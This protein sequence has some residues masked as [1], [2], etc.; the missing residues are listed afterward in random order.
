ML[1]S[2]FCAQARGL[3]PIALCLLTGLLS[4]QCPI[5]VNAGPDLY[6]CAPTSPAQLD[7]SISG[8]YL[9]FTWTPTT[10][11]QGANTLSPTV[12]VTQTT[13]YVLKATAANFSANTIDNG[14]FEQ[15]N[16]GFT[17]D[18]GYNPGNLMP[19][20]VYDVIDNPQSD[21]PGFAPCNDHTSGSGNMMVVNG[22]GSPNQ[23]VWCQTVVVMPNT[24]Y[25]LSC[26]VT[27]VVAVSPALLQFSINGSSVGPI[28]QAPG[29][30]CVWQNFYSTWNSGG[31]SSATICVVNQNTGLGG[32]DFALDD[33]VFAPVCMQTDTVKVNVITITAVANPNVYTIPCAGANITLSGIGS[34]TGASFTYAWDTPTGN[35]VSGE[36]TLNPV[37]NAPGSYTLTVTYDGNG[38]MCTKTATVNVIESPNPLS[39]WINPTQPLGCGAPTLTLIGN[40]SQSGFSTYQWTTTNGNILNNPNQ[41]NILINQ[42]GEYDLLV[43]NSNTGCTATASIVVTAATSAPTA[44]ATANGPLT[45]TQTTATLSGAGSS[46]GATIGY[47]WTTF[48]GGTISSGQ[49]SQN[50]VAGSA[51]TYVLAVTNSSSGC[52]ATDTVVLAANTAPPTTSIQP[53]GVLDCNTDTLSL[54][55]TVMPANAAPSWTA[56][57]GG[58]IAGGQNTLSPLVTAA[59]TYTLLATNPV[60]GCTASTAVVVTANY[61]PPLAAAQSPNNLTCQSPSVTLSG[62]G[63]STG[64]NM[65][66][67]WT[68]SPGGNIVSGGATLSPVVNAAGTYTLLV[69]NTTN[70]CTATAGVTV[71]ADQNVL[72]AMANAPDT[73]NCTAT[74]VILNSTGSSSG[75]TLFYAWTTTNGNISGPANVP[76]PTATLPG[77]YQLL[78]TNS[79]NGCSATDLAI[80]AQNVT[81]PQLQ[82]SIPAPGFLS[83]AT[84]S[85][86]LQGQ[87]GSLPG[88]FTYQWTAANGGNIVSNPTTLTP[89]VNTGGQYTLTATN[90]ANGCTG[91]STVTLTTQTGTPVATIAAPGPLTCTTPT[92]TL[93]TA[94]SS[95]GAN[96]GYSWTA[97]N[98]GNITMGATTPNLVVSAAGTY[99]LL[100]TN[101]T[102][103]CTTTAS[104][105]VLADQNV[106][107]ALANAPDTLNCT[108]TTV[109][110]NSTGSS[111][112]PTLVYAW[113]TTNGNFS[114][115]TNVP[116]PIATLP[117]TYQLL[118]TNTANGCTA[119]D[120]ALVNQN[121]TPPQLQI[122]TPAPGFLSCATPSLTLQGQNGSLPGNFAYQWTVANGGNIVSNPTT[123]TPTVN[124]GGQYTLT[125]TN[126][127]NG[128]TGQSTVTLTAQ[129]STPVATIAAPGP[130][131]CTAQ[132]QTLNSA[133]SSA[134]AN[135]AYSWTAAN[136]GNITMGAT[137][138]SPIVNAA[139]TYNLLISNTYNGCT[140]S[141]STVVVANNTPPPAEAGAAGLLTCTEPVF[142]LLGNPA[143]PTANLVFQWTT[144]NGQFAGNPNSV[145]VNVDQAGL[146]QLLVTDPAN[147]CT[148]TDSVQVAANQQLPAVVIAPP[149][150]LTCS[151]ST[152]TLSAVATGSAPAYQWQTGAGQIVSGSTS[153]M[154]LIAASGSYALTVTDGTNGCT[155]SASVTVTED[156]A[157]PDVQTA[158]VV[159]I[160]CATPSQTITGQ[161][162]SLPGTFTYNWVAANGG[163]I[164]SGA[165]SLLPTVDAG[166]DYM[167]TTT[168]TDNGCTSVLQVTVAQNTVL[169]TANAGPDS[170]LS[171]SIN[172]LMIN[173]SGLGAPNLA[174]AWTASNGGNLVSGGATPTPAIDQP[175]SYTLLV[176][177]PANGCT[178]SDAVQ[179]QNDVNAPQAN[180]GLPA[181]L[182]CTVQ[183]TTLNATA[184]QGADFSY[185]WT[186]MNGNL[187]SN[188]TTLSPTVN[189]PGLYQFAVTNAAN[190]CVSTSTVAVS[191]DVLPPVIDAG[192]PVTLSCALPALPLAGTA[193]GTPAVSWTT[194][195]GN[196]ISGAGTLTPPVNQ[197]GTYLLTAT[198]PANGCTATDNVTVGIDT[199][200]PV[201]SAGTA[202]PLN[203]SA[204][205]TTV[206]GNVTTPIGPFTVAWT[207][208]NGHFSG[209]QN[210]LSALVDAPG[211]YQ[212]TI[213][214]TSNGC[215]STTQTTVLQNIMLPT[216]M[217]GAPGQIT[218]TNPG[219]ALQGAGSSLG[220]NYEYLW[221][222]GNGGQIQSGQT[223]L[224]PL[225]TAGGTYALVVTD[226]SNG[227]QATAT[228]TVNLNT[229]PPTVAILPPQ[230][231]T[232]T[233]L[234][235]LLNA[236]GSSVGANFTTTWTTATGHFVNGQTTLQP[237]VDQ[238][239]VY[240]LTIEHTGNGCTATAEVTVNKNVVPPL[241]EAGPGAQLHC[242]QTEVVLPGSSSTTGPLTFAWSTPDGHIQSSS[243]IA[244]PVADQPGAYTLTVTDAGNGCTATDVT[245][246]TEIPP[247][248]FQPTLWAPDCFDPTGDVDFGPVTGGASPFRY[249]T[250]GGLTFRNDPTFEDLLPG[251]HELLVED[252]HGCTAT[253]TVEVKLPF[254]PTV[255]LTGVF[256]LQQGDSIQLLPVLNLPLSSVASW[257]WT[258]AADL[259]CVDCAQPWA[260]PLRSTTYALKITDLNGCVAEA[261]TQLRVNRKR[262]L[263]APN[264]F[265]P[266]DDGR[267]D[268]FVLYG[269]GV[270]E[271][272]SLRIFDRWGS[273]LFLAEHLTIGDEAAGWGGDF[274]GDALNPAVFVWQ[275]AVEFVDGEVEIFSGDVTLVR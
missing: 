119:T 245:T 51:G 10:G 150:P 224:T 255:T 111:N 227:C 65:L 262:N 134:G 242:Q 222:A 124:A 173:G 104:V 179:I 210:T 23:N 182:T 271:V 55:A 13:S 49:N 123:L 198:D 4:A 137:S 5:T 61:S 225:V 36:T 145:Q 141:A 125:A 70:A 244:Q 109:M 129:T 73:L 223:T 203:C 7:G 131:N 253:Q 138:P 195:N 216:A 151:Q 196:L 27:S 183:Q 26:W 8:D 11:L 165:T 256:T 31:N 80:V 254:L 74:T 15:G 240:Q 92:Q 170:T 270:K 148:A 47:A 275:A 107:T 90:L 127:A 171:C 102:N 164:V 121:V 76:N 212:L 265:S 87:N 187:V 81:T 32:N 207:T 57:G 205:T 259:S 190:G 243:S 97:T 59:G 34:S 45:C 208:T 258:P 110:L 82:V 178:A 130:I 52:I 149:M 28:F 43:T 24:Q 174:Y 272:R 19:E 248:A 14:D 72:T 219:I 218:C 246:V 217:A 229:T 160:T 147:G 39:A 237:T 228:T 117:G 58:Q 161:N 159:A 50:A 18:Y 100:V 135:F 136:G 268:R 48:G 185:Q 257:Q 78:I 3:L 154:P 186:T 215:T 206:S 35:I 37:V 53:P 192:P 199:L 25:V 143:L 17:S 64:V 201:I 67:A 230:A 85:L 88:N 157:L 236:G 1:T 42:P 193:T 168:N 91:Q 83:C 62:S 189:A 211:V 264:V 175:G 69:T 77:T 106:L 89:T 180:A 267:N 263:Y 231:L 2:S 120:L 133:G 166:G 249:S 200:H 99:T 274:R 140:A 247:P 220:A 188:A 177:N 103:A 266:N 204:L 202:G 163:N 194:A 142:Y 84:P 118:L 153:P 12:T 108:A 75:P 169:P 234:S 68:S 56:T 250:D 209:P 41:K 152:A 98:G 116:N 9:G 128:C 63:S 252:Q 132:T 176:T 158:P 44:N 20:G 226:M 66:Y 114:G 260:K 101:T 71:L 54:A 79:A 214:L 96:F 86:T 184:S 239:G 235:V 94:G 21:H 172:A 238:P 60:N 232:C 191:E 40:S 144:A 197:A 6:L 233:R 93:N 167:L 221:T 29:Q 251:L 181:T 261:S 115:P 112:G 122:T 16:S 146:Y 213:Q 162:L 241:A 95:T 105:T 273:E 126:L 155:S 30:N 113:S 139:G 22:A 38:V 269:K 156:K 33:I 46:T